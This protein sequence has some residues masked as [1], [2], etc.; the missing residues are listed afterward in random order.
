MTAFFTGCSF[1]YGD[2]LEN[3]AVEAWPSLIG[4][5]KQI[6]F[7]NNAASG[8]SNERI[9]YQVIKNLHKH[10][11]FYIA[12]TDISRF[13][14]YFS[15][16]H[17]INFNVQ[18]ANSRFANDPCFLDYGNLHYRYWYNELFSF[19]LW[20]QQVILL[21]TY[22]DANSKQ[23]IMI[24]TFDNHI[25]R[26]TS[27]WNQFNNSVQSLLCFDSMDDEQLFQE[28][29]EIKKLEK[30]IDTDRFL[31]WRDITLASL[32]KDYPKGPTKHPLQEGHQVIAEYI[33]KHDTN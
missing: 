17:E 15:D 32:T 14:R 28:H 24:N 21:Q 4:N 30:Q 2:D 9:V 5:K 6:D 23:W 31:G 33:L 26:W 13:T 25:K 19:K 1:T 3:R 22:L 8:S 20:L 11:K 7:V 29:L 16:N 12:W 10:D 27:D 18:L